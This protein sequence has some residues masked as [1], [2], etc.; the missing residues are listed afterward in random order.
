M[1]QLKR[2]ILWGAAFTVLFALLSLGGGRYLAHR[3]LKA[4]ETRYHLVVTVRDVVPQF[5]GL[6]LRDVTV[7]GERFAFRAPA[8]SLRLS[9]QKGVV[10]VVEDGAF[11]FPWDS[12]LALEHLPPFFLEVRGA[13][14]SGFPMGFRWDGWVEKDARGNLHFAA[15]SGELSVTGSVGNVVSF[16][17]MYR[18]IPF[19]GTFTLR[20]REFSGTLGDVA[21]EG[22]LVF[23]E[24]KWRIAHLVAR[25]DGITFSGECVMAQGGAFSLSGM[26]RAVAQEVP[27][28]LSGRFTFPIFEG[29]LRSGTFSGHITMDVSEALFILSIAP[30]SAWQGAQVSGNL[31]GCFRN[32]MT[33]KLREVL[34]HAPEHNLSFTLSGELHEDDGTLVG[35]VTLS[36]VSGEIQGIPFSEG[37]V[38]AS[39]KG[40]DIRFAGVG[41]CAGGELSFSGTY[42]EGNLRLQG[43]A[44]GIALSSL[45]R[46]RDIPL[47]GVLSGN[48]FLEGQGKH[49]TVVFSLNDGHLA[50]K[51]VDLGRIASG[52]VVF[53][54]DTVTIR[55]LLLVRGDGRFSG[56][57]ALNSWGIQGK[58]SFAAYPLEWLLGERKVGLIVD[59]DVEFRWGEERFLRFALSVPSWSFDTFR[60]RNLVLEGKFD[61]RAVYLE[62]F[63]LS[64]DGGSFV[65]SGDLVLGERVNL[66]GELVNL[67]VPE[68]F[69]VSGVVEHASLTIS[70]PWEDVH[71]AFEGKGSAF[72]AGTLPLGET[73]AIKLSG[74]ASLSQ[75]LEGERAL[76]H[77]LHPE[78]L[79]EGEIIASRVNLALLGG[80]AL[81]KVQGTFDLGLTL[82]A[83]KK[84]WRFRAEAPCLS[85]PPFGDVRGNVQGV[86]DG[87]WFTVERLV[88]EGKGITL[89][90]QGV[91]DA[92]GKTL[93][94]SVSG[95]VTT[96]IPFSGYE[97]DLEAEGSVHV[98][99]DVAAP[100]LEGSCILRKVRVVKGHQEYL[101]LEGVSGKLQGDTLTLSGG[102]G[103]FLGGNVVQLHGTVA[104]QSF[105]LSASLEGSGSFPGLQGVFE[106]QW[107]G[108]LELSRR[109]D[110]YILEGNIAVSRALIDARKAQGIGAGSLATLEAFFGEFP[111]LVK[112]RITL[113]DMLTVKTDFLHL[114][115]SGGMTVYVVDGKLSLHGKFDVSEGMYDLVA[116]TIP[117]EGYIVFTEFGGLVPELHLE[118]RKALE[119]Y[120]IRVSIQGPLSDYTVDFVAEPPLAREEVL[121]LLFFGDKDAYLAPHRIRLSPL[122]SQIAR[123]FLKKD[124]TLRVEPFFDAV[125]FDPQD[126]SRVTFEKRL[127]KNVAIG[128]TQ[129]LDGGSAFEMTVDFTREWSFRFERNE[130]GDVEWM[131]QFATKF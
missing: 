116:C 31:E 50:L 74:K 127:G 102:S 115:L 26:V 104:S 71:W 91:F 92:V 40:R 41:K 103:V 15:K 57:F 95:E 99:G 6:S 14:L 90:G 96:C 4:L 65:A 80:K 28:S 88:L 13:T 128:Y 123:F 72:R 66:T 43:V 105:L 56:M 62:R 98:A 87:K 110:Q 76:S 52:E 129:D 12:P 19:Q 79:E 17:G 78:N 100:S 101:H 11:S 18:T 107:K 124:W 34:V 97:V 85:F 70:G 73:V 120:D 49:W 54:E 122:L 106:G 93:D 126:F 20:E 75:L 111:I 22:Q 3:F 86:Y 94:L 47:S 51:G 130:D 117:L 89:S 68:G 131:L 29:E 77:V 37:K 60:G 25:R 36:D 63:A 113:Q 8:L 5:L 58:G 119:G 108:E 82:D 61:G 69:E 48:L 39:L 23:E 27:V 114:C 53:L 35:E 21:L 81:S 64:W 83:R 118:G 9:W 45:F 16:S 24:G 121:S 1:G 42:R 38:A 112:L 2:G 84:V 30:G 125:V 67:R 10:L 59:G 33:L 7:C 44:Q 32:G 55:N 109:G 46:G